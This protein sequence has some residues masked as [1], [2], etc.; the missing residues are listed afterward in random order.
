MAEQLKADLFLD[1]KGLLCPLP[2]VKLSQAIKDLPVGAII[3][4]VATDPGVMADVPAWAKASGQ[5]LI[6]I[7][8][9]GKEYRFMIKKVK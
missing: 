6:S 1:L 4:G 8:Q 7:E 2:I 9:Q 5:E 3:E